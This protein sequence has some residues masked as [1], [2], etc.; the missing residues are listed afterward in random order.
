MVHVGTP[1]RQ[2]LLSLLLLVSLPSSGGLP[3]D[4]CSTKHLYNTYMCASIQHGQ[5]VHVIIHVQPACI[6][7]YSI[8]VYS[9]IIT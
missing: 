4:P 1:L 9:D 6:Y 5:A 3:L 2:T 7:M 8:K